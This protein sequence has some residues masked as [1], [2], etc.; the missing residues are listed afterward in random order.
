[1][2]SIYER[3]DSPWLW[4]KYRDADGKRVQKATR[5]R[6]DDPQGRDHAEQ[7]LRAIEAQVQAERRHAKGTLTLAKYAGRWVADRIARGVS[8]AKDDRTRLERHVLPVLGDMPLRDVGPE[9]LRELFR[10]LQRGRLAPKTVL[11]VYATIR[12]L[13]DDALAARL[14]TATPAILKRRRGELP[15][16]ADRDPS[17][18]VSAV[19]RRDEV[20]RLLTDPRIPSDRRMIY[21]LAFLTGMRAG[22]LVARTWEEYDAEAAPLGVIHVLSAWR[23]KTKQRSATKTKRVRHVPVHPALAAMLADWKLSGWARTY[24]RKPA[25]TDYIV[26]SRE[27]MKPRTNSQMWERFKADCERIGLRPRR[28]HDARR[29]FISLAQADGADRDLLRWVTHGAPSD[30]LGDYTTLPWESLCR[31]V[32]KFRLRSATE[33]KNPA[34]IA[35]FSLGTAGFEPSRVPGA[36]PKWDAV[37]DAYANEGAHGDPLDPADRSHAATEEADP[38][39]YLGAATRAGMRVRR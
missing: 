11:N 39:G 25:P 8:S 34:N 30:I 14:I 10:D 27:R 36:S 22:E 7:V 23:S 24:G 12:T 31:E 33:T 28:V 35:G 29:T 38:S 20:A 26:P 21:A 15:E 6:R 13:F 3:P 16:K 17:W 18:R 9:H 4:L 1:M 2:G 32:S 37:A 5:F 19:F